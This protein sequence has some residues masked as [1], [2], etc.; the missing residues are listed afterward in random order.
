MKNF[1]SNLSRNH[2][3]WL[4]DAE[5]LSAWKPPTLS[6]IGGGIKVFNY[7]RRSML[8]DKADIGKYVVSV[9]L[10]HP[11]EHIFY[12]LTPELKLK[13]YGNVDTENFNK[14][15]HVF[16][17]LKYIDL[18]FSTNKKDLLA[19][20]RMIYFDVWKITEEENEILLLNVASAKQR[21][22]YLMSIMLNIETI[23]LMKIL[24]LNVKNVLNQSTI[25]Q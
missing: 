19:N 2:P 6:F 15:F 23:L 5:D 24:F 7:M 8:F 18:F 1:V 20:Y 10:N 4:I 11:E 13:T 16:K 22:K 25:L 17:T 12:F 9:V 14:A 3:K 21:T